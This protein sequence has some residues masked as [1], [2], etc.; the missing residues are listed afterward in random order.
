MFKADGKR[1]ATALPDPS[2]TI[3]EVG[4]ALGFLLAASCRESETG[5]RLHLEQVTWARVKDGKVL[6]SRAFD[7]VVVYR[8]E[9]GL[10]V[11]QD[12]LSE[13]YLFCPSLAP[14]VVV[15]ISLAQYA[16]IQ[17][18]ITRALVEQLL[19]SVRAVIRRLPGF[20]FKGES[21]SGPPDYARAA[22]R[23]LDHEVLQL[24]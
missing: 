13:Q 18:A 4:P 22:S 16:G 10:F 23:R 7:E 12:R 8:H 24:E 3:I 11:A 5:G 21:L 2:V 17:Q 1:A 20:R 14:Y 6:K 19:E 15:F 9:S